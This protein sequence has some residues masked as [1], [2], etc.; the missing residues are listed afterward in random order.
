MTAARSG[1][2]VLV[3]AGPE[4]PE[5]SVLARLPEGATVIAVG[6]TVEALDSTLDP[7]A[8]SSIDVVLNCGVG[9]ASERLCSYFYYY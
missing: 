6:Q 2:N 1:A 3:V 7:S 9:K 8:W 5:L 4:A